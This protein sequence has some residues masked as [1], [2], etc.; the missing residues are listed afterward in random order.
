M[1]MKQYTCDIYIEGKGTVRGVVVWLTSNSQAE[2]RKAAEAQFPGKKIATATN[3]K[4]K[5]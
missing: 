4:E 1:P 2:A 5:K 3:V